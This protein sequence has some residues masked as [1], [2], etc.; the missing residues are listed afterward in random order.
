MK[1]RSRRLMLIKP[2]LSADPESD[3]AA[4][5]SARSDEVSSATT[6]SM[7]V[8]LRISFSASIISRVMVANLLL[9]LCVLVVMQL[10]L[11][12]VTKPWFLHTEPSLYRVRKERP[13]G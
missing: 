3:A 4:R 12:P 8:D 10:H 13:T 6:T 11:S 7:A 1:T 2:D 9:T 5:T